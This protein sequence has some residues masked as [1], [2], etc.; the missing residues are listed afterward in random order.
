MVST[1]RR[2]DLD[3]IRILAFATLILYHVAMYYVSWDWH[4]KSPFASKTLEPL[5]MLTNPW[6]LPLLFLVSGAAT[7]FIATRLAPGRLA[8]SRTLRL[9]APLA[10]GILVVVPPQSYFEV[11]EKA[12]YA[13]GFGAFLL[14]YWTADETFC[15]GK[16]CLIV[17]TWNHLWFVMYLWVYT[18]ALALVLARAPAWR[19]RV[20]R[21]AGRA[22]SG[23]GV[24]W[25]PWLALAA[26]RLF[27]VGRFGST[28]AL[29]DDWYN[30]ALFFTVFAIGFLVAHVD[31]VWAAMERA[32]WIALFLALVTYAFLVWYFFLRSNPDQPPEALRLF[33]RAL[34]AL[35]Q[36]SALVAACGFARRHIRRDSPARRYLTD[37]IFPFYIVHQTAIIAFAVW[38]RPLGLS[39]LAEA[40]LLIALVAL[41]CVA[42]YEAAKRV[43]WLRP[44]FG[45]KALSPPA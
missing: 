45:L 37:A 14:R 6:R 17:P 19:E 27:L 20:S 5:M 33:Q 12:G 2:I 8:E 23:W 4:V 39:P 38:M 32:R 18:M 34:Y 26:A 1:E 29:I 16:D 13:E 36:W 7:A 30:H 21:A 22:L 42:T 25:W 41:V 15:R 24:L 28:H 35:N 9:L 31:A 43:S 3:W 44:L 10:F 40:P 11:V